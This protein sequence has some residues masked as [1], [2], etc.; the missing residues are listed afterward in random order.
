MEKYFILL[1]LIIILFFNGNCNLN[2]N[3]NNPVNINNC[4]EKQKNEKSKTLIHFILSKNAQH[5]LLLNAD[6][7]D[8]ERIE[9]NI[10]FKKKLK[11]TRKLKKNTKVIEY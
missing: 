2:C 1:L 7:T 4:L 9:S 6:Y 3:S 8:K 5:K 10:I 11:L